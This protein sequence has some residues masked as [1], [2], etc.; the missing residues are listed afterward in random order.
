MNKT[1]ITILVL[2]L[3]LL[4]TSVFVYKAFYL[5][6]P[7][8]ADVE[9]P[10]W[11]IEA[12]LTF[13]GRSRPAKASVWIPTSSKNALVLD[14]SFISRGFGVNASQEDLNRQAVW[15]IRHAQGFHTLY[16]RAVVRAGEDEI[17]KVTGRAPEVPESEYQDAL[18]A[19]AD[20][21]LLDITR[22]SADTEGLVLG[23]LRELHRPSPSEAMK[24]LLGRNKSPAAKASLAVRILAHGKI[25]ARVV[26][27]I[28][29]VDDARNVPVI[30]WLEVYEAEKRVWQPYDLFW[31]KKGVP[32]HYFIWWY[33]AEPLAHVERGDHLQTIISV[34]RNQERAISSVDVGGRLSQSKLLEFSLFSLPLQTQA[35]YRTLLTVPLGVFL[36]IILRNMVG[37]KTFGTFMPVLIALAFRETDLIS[38]IILFSIIVASGLLVRFYLEQLKLLLVPR[39]GAVLIVVVLLMVAMSVITYKLGI[40]RGVSIALFPMVIMTMT[41]ERMSIVWEE[42]GA[43]DAMKQGF[44]TLL[45]ASLCYLV[46][47]I[48]ALSH[49]VFVFP[50]SLLVLLAFTLL[51]GRYTGYRLVELKRFKVL[52]GEG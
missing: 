48:P 28:R 21:V 17:E 14:E 46:M 26:N 43:S 8:T 12:R 4:G 32:N 1:H 31:K 6:F 40:D 9:S 34:S 45:S 22:S 38:G 49:F 52:A 13:S 41:I 35:V 23:L 16:Y 18:K 37:I 7:L 3:I 44:G 24:L 36:L 30:Q 15:S 47:T 33:G 20:Q 39:L 50:E 42:R 29:L 19:A 27:G 25:P 5:H 2:A 10:L 11:N 51:L